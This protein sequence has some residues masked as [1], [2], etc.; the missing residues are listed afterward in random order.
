MVMDFCFVKGRRRRVMGGRRAGW[1]GNG[2]DG[3]RGQWGNGR[4][5]RGATRFV[6][7]AVRD[8]YY[9]GTCCKSGSLSPEVWGGGD[10][11]GAFTML[12]AR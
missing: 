11:G 7:F 12:S 9:A 5:E 2:N 8:L 3:G 4:G 1:R 10:A 6:G